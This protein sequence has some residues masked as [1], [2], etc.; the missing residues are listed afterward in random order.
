MVSSESGA[1]TGICDVDV[2]VQFAYD[3]MV[4]EVNAQVLGRWE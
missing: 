4:R 3:G 2:A 1:E